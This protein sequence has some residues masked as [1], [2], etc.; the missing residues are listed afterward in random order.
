MDPRSATTERN[1]LPS[2]GPVFFREGDDV[3][4]QFVI[5]P[6]NIVGP[7]LARAQDVRAH[8]EAFQA[9]CSEHGPCSEAEMLAMGFQ[10]PVSATVAAPESTQESQ[11]PA[12]AAPK[13]ARKPRKKA[14]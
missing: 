6:G 3:L 14:G 9:F 1:M 2:V 7:R 4:F 8:G 11:R 12:E 10:Q 5:D 13:V